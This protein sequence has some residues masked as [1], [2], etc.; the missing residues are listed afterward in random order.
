MKRVSPQEKA[1]RLSNQRVGIESF[2]NVE[3]LFSGWS[4]IYTMKG[5]DMDDIELVEASDKLEKQAMAYIQDYKD[6]GEKLINGSS[7]LIDYDDYG[8]WLAQVTLQKNKDKSLTDTPATTYFTIRKRDSKIIGSIQLRHHLTEE[9]LRDG[10]NVGYGICP[11]ERN[12]G[13]GTRQLAL[14]LDQAKA[15]SLTR[16][17]I[18]CNKDNRASAKVA[19]NNGGILSGVG[20]DEDEGKKTEIYWITIT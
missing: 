2:T 3:M 12:K 8:K 1:S 20:F 11:S 14:A 6:N 9:L 16:I 7:G 17:M 19:L 10:G 15:L 5:K 13:Y 4:G 18:S